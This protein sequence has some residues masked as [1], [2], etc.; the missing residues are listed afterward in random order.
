MTSCFCAQQL[1]DDT[2]QGQ[3]EYHQRAGHDGGQ[4][5]EMRGGFSD[6]FGAASAPQ[7]GDE[8]VC[9]HR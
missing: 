8:D 6:V 3:S 7:L 4:S 5:E 1:H 2:I 9:T